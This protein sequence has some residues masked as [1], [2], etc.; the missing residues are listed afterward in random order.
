MARSNKYSSINFNDIYEKKISSSSTPTKNQSSKPPPPSSS[1]SSA[2]SPHN[3]LTNGPYK[4]HL[5]QGR[6]LVLTR[7]TPT[8]TPAPKPITA[9]PPPQPTPSPLPAQNCSEPEPEPDPIS[10]RPLGRT[11]TGS[12]LPCRVPVLDRDKEALFAVTSPKPDKFVPPHL[13]PG[14]AGKEE[15][16]APGVRGEPV[17][18]QQGYYGSP[19]RYAEDGRPKSGGYEGM[20]GGGQADLNRTSSFG[21]RPSSSG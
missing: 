9:P 1:Y 11:G 20:K 18:R 14:F 16:P 12:A 7:P 13:R 8:P 17:P 10:L 4:A 19:G 6:M 2:T 15:R 21:N 3:A 5:T